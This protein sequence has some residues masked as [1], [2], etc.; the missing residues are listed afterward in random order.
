MRCIFCL[1]ERPSSLEHV[2]PLAIG[3]TITTDRVCEDCNPRLG[4]PVDAALIHFLPVVGRRAE[5]GLVGHSGAVPGPFDI[6]MGEAT[7]IGSPANRV[8]TSFNK[9]TGQFETRQLYHA[10]DVELED[11]RKVRQITLDVNDK[12]RIPK[13]IQRERR[14]HGLPPLSEK[15][16][17]VEAQN[18]TLRTIENP[19]I[20]RQIPANFAYLGHAMAKIAYEL[21]FLWLGESYLDDPRAAELRAAIL[22][23]DLLATNALGGHFGEA[24]TCQPFANVWTANKA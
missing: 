10:E 11:G 16:L 19:V 23:P 6:L 4:S 14:R 12:D 7:L 15:A 1:N 17:A 2:F 13:I 21:A 3:G 20:L 24:E 18:Y 5:L 8:R 22:D 9:R